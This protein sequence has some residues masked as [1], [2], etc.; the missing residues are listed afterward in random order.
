MRGGGGQLDK[1][2][3]NAGQSCSFLAGGAELTHVVHGMESFHLD[4]GGVAALEVDRQDLNGARILLNMQN[5]VEE[6]YK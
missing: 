3:D 1:Q 5:T 4:I 2:R 6:L